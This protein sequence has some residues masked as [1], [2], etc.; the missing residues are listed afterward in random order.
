MAPVLLFEYFATPKATFWVVRL[1]ENKKE[2]F[3][4]SLQDLTI[5]TVK[6]FLQDSKKSKY[7]I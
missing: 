1:A 6:G 4:K 7:K 2:S 5:E 3:G